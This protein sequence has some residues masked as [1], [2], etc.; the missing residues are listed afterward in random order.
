[1]PGPDRLPP[2][3]TLSAFES[4]ARLAS[5]TAAARE[6]GSTQ[7]AVSQR[8]VQ[9]EEDLGAPLFE[10]G[11]RGVTLTPEG[12][13]LY[14]A[15]RS[16]LDTIREAT[17]DIRA[18]RAT[19]A[20]TILTDAGFA[21]YWLMPRLARLKASMP[22]VNVKIVTSQ[23]GYDPHRDHADIAIAFGDGHWPPCTST[24]LFAEAVTPICSPAF[25]DLHASVSVAADLAALPLLHVQPTD[26][27]RWLAWNT[28]FAAQGLQAP[29]DSQGMMFNSY[30]LVVQAALMGQGVALGWTPLTDELIAS[31]LLVRLLDTPVTTERGY[32]LV[33]PPARPAPAA[34]PLFRRWVFNELIDIGEHVHA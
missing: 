16:G 28:W 10:R 18:R 3:Q 11:H 24:R 21:T 2:M 19:G 32:Y 22:G 13:L 27:E 30:S 5:F 7:P 33:C 6:L 4:A 8:I 31:G 20:L 26:P 14:E 25:R 17:S 34:V 15:V 23:L 1:M 12:A 29:E 9:L